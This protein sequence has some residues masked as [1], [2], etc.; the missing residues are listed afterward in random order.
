VQSEWTITQETFVNLQIHVNRNPFFIGLNAGANRRIRIKV[1]EIHPNGYPVASW[2]KVVR[3]PSQVFAGVDKWV[4]VKGLKTGIRYAVSF[5]SADGNPRLWM[6]WHI[7]DR[8]N[9]QQGQIQT[10]YRQKP[11]TT[12]YPAPTNPGPGGANGVIIEPLD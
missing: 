10:F 2:T 11:L 7:Q 3:M 5:E 8:Y 12:P 1:I 6:Q 9:G 4:R